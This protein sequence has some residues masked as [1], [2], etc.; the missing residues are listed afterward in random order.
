MGVCRGPT[1][2]DAQVGGAGFHLVEPGVQVGPPA[3]PAHLQPLH[4]RHLHNGAPSNALTQPLA[5]ST[6][7]DDALK[8]SLSDCCGWSDLMA[9]GCRG[10]LRC[11]WGADSRTG[12][13]NM[14]GGRLLVGQMGRTTL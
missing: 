6:T 7:P 1:A 5:A 4:R 10:V 12:E 11:G 8:T 13:V 9:R 3:V 2:L 14:P